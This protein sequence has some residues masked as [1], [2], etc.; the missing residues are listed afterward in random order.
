MAE[1][2]NA[3]SH[4]ELIIVHR[5]GCRLSVIGFWI[6]SIETQK[7]KTLGIQNTRSLTQLEATG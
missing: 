2:I 6:H 4:R 1:I 5:V 7:I 3:F